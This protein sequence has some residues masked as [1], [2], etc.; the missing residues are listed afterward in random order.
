[1]QF[2]PPK[3]KEGLKVCF[4]HYNKFMKQYKCYYKS[5]CDTF[6]SHKRKITTGLISLYLDTYIN[7]KIYSIDIKLVPGKKMCKHRNQK[8][9]NDSIEL[10]NSYN[11]F[12]KKKRALAAFQQRSMSSS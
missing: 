2:E 12:F 4:R 11:P 9:K 8:I 6:E 1:M 5:W 10:A 7:Y 3:F